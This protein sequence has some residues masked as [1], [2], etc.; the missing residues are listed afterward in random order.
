M[1]DEKS[2]EGTI[3][4]SGA[5][6]DTQRKMPSL[7]P[8]QTQHELVLP[9]GKLKYTATAGSLPLK[10]EKG[11]TEA[12]IFFVAYTKD[13]VKDVASRPLVFAFNGGPG[14]AAIWLHMGAFG[15]YRVE[16]EAEGWMPSPPYHLVPN[17]FTWLE[18]ADLVFIDPVGTGFSR[19]ASE[20]LDKKFWSVKGDIESTGEVI[21]LYL[22]RYQR[23]SSP[24]FL[25]GESYGTTRA[26]GLAGH[27]VDRGIA[28]NGVV[29]ISTA[30]DLR[31]IFFEQSDDLP[32]PLFV[33]SYTATAWYHQRLP[34]DLQKR[35]LE[36]LLAEVE[37]WAE[38]DYVVALMKGD[39]LEEERESEIAEQ[40][41]RYTG[42][43]V[44]YVQA[45]NLRIQI[46]RFCKEL[47]RG[48][49]RSVGRLDSRFQGIEAEDVKEVPE[50]DP[51]ML[52]VLPP[53]TSTF[54]DYV[55]RELGV[56]TDLAYEALSETV[57]E[58]WEWEKGKLPTTG[59]SLRSAFA[60]HPHMHVFIGQG[61]YDLATPHFA[62][63]YMISHMNVD[64]SLRDQITMRHYQAGHMFYLDTES[65]AAFTRDVTGFIQETA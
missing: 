7:E 33:P 22:S 13:G 49:K 18:H 58:K 45:S 57:N 54:N 17:E 19:A 2:A 61:Y 44:E 25:A 56:E 34:E 6:Q 62:T 39:Q 53:Y 38:S 4:E 52:A 10:D 28:F 3:E 37:A 1:A 9:T 12:E 11:S 30:L 36:E 14:S 64:R 32:F 26:A 35:A 16:M 20:E 23:W 63:A 48:E 60:K 55:R 50:F 29:L 31:A 27:L 5:K 40:L 41:A 8:V 21:R 65:L 46:H 24:L 47:R 43:T 59:E 51:S 42:L 15:P